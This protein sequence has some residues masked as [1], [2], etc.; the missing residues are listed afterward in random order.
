MA[1]TTGKK[2]SKYDFSGSIKKTISSPDPSYAKNIDENKTENYVQIADNTDNTSNTNNTS[3]TKNISNTN[4]TKET[5]KLPVD[6]PTEI[7]IAKAKDEVR[8][9]PKKGN[10]TIRFSITILGDGEINKIINARRE[11]AGNRS[12][13]IRELIVNDYI[14]NRDKYE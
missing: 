9:N 1:A 6:V 14:Q 8:K 4:V 5:Y 11:F 3:V 12:M 10:N 2:G 13:F 7:D